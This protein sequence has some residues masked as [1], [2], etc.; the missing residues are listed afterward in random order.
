MLLIVS[1]IWRKPNRIIG[2]T[3]RPRSAGSRFVREKSRHAL[4][5]PV[6]SH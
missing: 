4:A 3:P 2:K 1:P 5:Q 6:F